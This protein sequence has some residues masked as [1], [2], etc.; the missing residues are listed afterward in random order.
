MPEKPE[1]SPEQHA[2]TIVALLT[3]IAAG[4]GTV[5]AGPGLGFLLGIVGA[6]A[7]VVV[8]QDE[9]EAERRKAQRRERLRQAARR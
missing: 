3:V 7:V 5:F 1:M 6:F 9:L 8:A 4:V 2:R